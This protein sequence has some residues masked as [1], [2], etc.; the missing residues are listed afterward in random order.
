MLVSRLLLNRV[1]GPPTD[2]H[3]ALF[4]MQMLVLELKTKPKTNQGLFLN[5]EACSYG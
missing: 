2:D 1:E 3:F 5:E 4:D